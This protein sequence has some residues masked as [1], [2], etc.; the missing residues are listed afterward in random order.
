MKKGVEVRRR[1]WKRRNGV[2]VRNG[3]LCVC[4]FWRRNE[5]LYLRGREKNESK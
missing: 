4:F 3:L 1:A 2:F 5:E